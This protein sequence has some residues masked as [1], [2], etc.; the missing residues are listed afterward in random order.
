MLIENKT[1]EA[2]AIIGP[3]GNIW[4]DETFKTVEEARSF[5]LSHFKKDESFDATKFST[6]P[7][8]VTIKVTSKIQEIQSTP[9][10]FSGE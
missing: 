6:V 10:P 1:Y 8:K 3:Y 5:L 2:F 9:T 7:V 4:C